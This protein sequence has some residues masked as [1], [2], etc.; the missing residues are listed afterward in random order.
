MHK[1][2]V[3]NPGGYKRM[4]H[5]VAIKS[6]K[7]LSSSELQYVKAFLDVGQID[8]FHEIVFENGFNNDKRV[9]TIKFMLE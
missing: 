8:E 2:N 4:T 9:S 1:M 3:N 7:I 5:Y 6:A